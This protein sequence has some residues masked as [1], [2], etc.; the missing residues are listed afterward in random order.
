M[1][2]TGE[3]SGWRRA[4][5]W[6]KLLLIVSLAL[7]V[8]VIGMIGG[9]AMRGGEKS[10]YGDKTAN[11]PGLDRRQS[12]I[13]RM[14]PEARRDA[15]RAILMARSAEYSAAQAALKQ[16]QMDLID[17]LRAEPFDP[18]RV[19]AALEARRQ[20]SGT[21]WGIGYE[22]LVQIAADLTAAERGELADSLEERTKRWLARQEGQS[23]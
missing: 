6:L 8:A 15:A 5:G 16:A 4:P 23:N 20:A 18:A 11:E 13:L 9:T 7:N 2:G 19:S 1:S 12:R 22:Q 17:A 3:S 10:E 14:V 21:V